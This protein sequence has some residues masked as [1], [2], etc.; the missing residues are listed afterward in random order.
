[1]HNL[2]NDMVSR[3]EYDEKEQECMAK[4]EQIQ[5]FG[6]PPFRSNWTFFFEILQAKIRRLEH[7][8]H[9]KDVRV[10]DLAG[11]LDQTR[12][13]PAGGN[14]G[15]AVRQGKSQVPVN[16]RKWTINVFSSSS[17]LLS[18]RFYPHVFRSTLYK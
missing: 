10:D 18:N 7:L 17:F 14:A 6:T 11:K 16:G 2:S 1:M 13:M 9:L 15:G 5:V 3:I 12:G 4:E 8:L